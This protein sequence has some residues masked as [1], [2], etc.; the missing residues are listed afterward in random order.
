[1]PRKRQN[2]TAEFK[3]QAVR[4]MTEQALSVAEVARQLGVSENCLRQWRKAFRDQGDSAFP[5]QGNRSPADEEIRRLRAELRRVE[6]ERDLLK[7]A[8][9][10]FAGLTT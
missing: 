3:A 7:K 9:T 4:L 5:G 8:A 1:M 6:A 2:Y 10:Y